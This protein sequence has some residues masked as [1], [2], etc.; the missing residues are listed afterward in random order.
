MEKL[1]VGKI[2]DRFIPAFLR[3][4]W[5]S[6]STS[7][8]GYRIAHGAF[9]SIMGTSIPQALNML[10]SI[11][12]ARLLGKVS[13]GEW[14]MILN[15][16]GM[17]SVFSGLAL[18]MAAVKHVAEFRLSNPAK[19]GRIIALLTLLALGI[20]VLM[21][22]FLI[23]AAPWLAEKTL[24]APHLANLLGIS[25]GIIFFGAL[26]GVQMGSLAGFEA[27]R[28]IAWINTINGVILFILLTVGVYF[29]GLPGAVWGMLV[30]GA[31][32]CIISNIELRGVAQN[33][34]VP[35]S[36]TGCSEEMY[37]LIEFS[38]PAV[39]A[40]IL[41][42][43]ANWACAA[44]LVNQTNGYAELGIYG[45]ASSWQ[46]VI[47]FLPQCLNTIALPMLSDFHGTKQNRQF[48]K[49]FWYNIIL[50]GG[51]AVAVAV[52]IALASPF[53]MKIYGTG[54]S[55]GRYVLMIISITGVVVAINTFIGVNIISK[56][57]A[58]FGFLSNS[59]W[60][61]ILVPMAYFLIPAYGAIGL[62]LAMLISYFLQTIWNMLYVTKH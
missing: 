14:G 60:A 51:S 5:E 37:I 4:Y 1:N 53:I 21:T 2:I 18:A 16:S 58:W 52:V 62:S 31:L 44:M 8:V 49:T 35:I 41:S 48:R 26:N 15:T 24:A 29:F 32:N 57:K 38:L 3:P 12:L 22:G 39:L 6:R 33:A 13:F 56:G 40:G 28:N 47:L 23:A 10:A 11:V 30:A 61:I 17:F 27:F 20:A 36:L 19:A 34:G 42:T 50:I 46:K 55:S 25:A 45:A 7:P 9:W 59:M 43:P 54:F